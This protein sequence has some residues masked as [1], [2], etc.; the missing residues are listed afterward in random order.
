MLT[1]EPKMKEEIL[2][3]LGSLVVFTMRKENSLDPINNFYYKDLR[4]SSVPFGP[5]YSLYEAMDHY[6]HVTKLFRA[7]A[8]NPIQ[9]PKLEPNN[10]I[11]V[12]FVSKKRVS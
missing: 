4:E 9:A 3:E 10:V 8:V 2:F 12:D 1:K 7:P 5:F 11:Y 6:K